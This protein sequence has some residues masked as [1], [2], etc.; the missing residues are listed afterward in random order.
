MLGHGRDVV[1]DLA[2]VEGALS[3]G[4][5]VEASD[6]AKIVGAAAESDPKVFIDV[7]VCVDDF[8]RGKDD[9]EV[10]DIVA[11]EA[12]AGAEEGETAFSE[13]EGERLAVSEKKM[14]E[15][16]SEGQTSHSYLGC[17]STR[18]CQTHGVELEVDI[19]PK[20]SCA[21]GCDGL[22]AGYGDGVDG[23]HVNSDTILNV[24]AAGPDGMASAA[25]GEFGGAIGCAQDVYGGGDILAGPG[26]D[27]AVWGD[28]GFLQGEVGF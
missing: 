26:G 10:D 27:D 8:T 6:D 20:S 17:A 5:E 16:T 28:F 13:E 22:I 18:G 2:A 14:I 25:D 21:N 12:K 23:P 1:E 15:R 4:A 19:L 7:G 11:N 24:G 3:E 9:L